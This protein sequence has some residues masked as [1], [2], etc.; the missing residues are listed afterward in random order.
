MVHA[1]VKY[2]TRMNAMIVAQREATAE[3]ISYAREVG[4]LR[5]QVRHLVVAC[6]FLVCTTALAISALLVFVTPESFR[7][8]REGIA[9]QLIRTGDHSMLSLQLRRI[10]AILVERVLYEIPMACVA[11][12]SFVGMAPAALLAAA[13]T[14]FLLDCDDA[15]A[16][17]AWLAVANLAFLGDDFGLSSDTS[18]VGIFALGVVFC[19]LVLPAACRRF[20]APSKHDWA[21]CREAALRH[22]RGIDSPLQDQPVRRGLLKAIVAKQMNRKPFVAWDTI[23]IALF[24]IA[25]GAWVL[26]TAIV[27]D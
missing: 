5:R 7:A 2:L 14:R 22:V 15:R 11:S 9:I 8:F 4:K 20:V 1:A 6:A 18:K 21:R 26:D 10:F 24:A 19:V 13:A 27:H 12:R 23:T 3:K 17:A 16:A 25:A